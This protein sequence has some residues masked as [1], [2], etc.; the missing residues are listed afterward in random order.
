MSGSARIE[1][2]MKS[3]SKD[4]FQQAYD[5]CLD[6]AVERSRSLRTFLDDI[7][8]CRVCM[9]EGKPHFAE[10]LKAKNQ[11]SIKDPHFSAGSPESEGVAIDAAWQ[12]F[13]YALATYYVT[14]GRPCVRHKHAAKAVRRREEL[15][16]QFRAKAVELASL[17]EKYERQAIELILTGDVEGAKHYVKSRISEFKIEIQVMAFAEALPDS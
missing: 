10:L 15:S 13:L 17:Y 5:A 6:V 9:N 16:R 11:L 4:F 8:H 2:A 12:R 7:V 3:L 1:T 14:S